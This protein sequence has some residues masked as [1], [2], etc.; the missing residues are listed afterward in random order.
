M[1][2]LLIVSICSSLT[3]CEHKPIPNT[4][5]MPIGE[6]VTGH[7]SETEFCKREPD[8]CDKEDDGGK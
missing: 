7:S 2:Y 5:V 1:K 3:A 4:E 6:A 8:Q